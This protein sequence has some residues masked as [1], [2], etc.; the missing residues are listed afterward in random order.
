MPIKCLKNIL[1][2]AFLLNGSGSILDS[3]DFVQT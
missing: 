1:E 2:I 3:L